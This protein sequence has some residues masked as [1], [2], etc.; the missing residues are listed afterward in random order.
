PAAGPKGYGLALMAELVGY[1]LLGGAREFNWLIVALPVSLF[2]DADEVTRA[3]EEVLAA[4]KA[5]PPAAGF[6]EVSFPGERQRQRRAGATG[7][8]V[9]PQV[10]ERLRDYAAKLG[11]GAEALGRWD[12]DDASGHRG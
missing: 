11:V 1:A 2:R 3:A 8:K 7:V 12:S 10:A 9:T 5:V 4:M 6:D